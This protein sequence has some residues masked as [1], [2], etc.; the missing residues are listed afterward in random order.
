[1]HVLSFLLRAP[2]P[3]RSVGDKLLLS[4]HFTLRSGVAVQAIDAGDDTIRVYVV[5]NSAG[6]AFDVNT[7]FPG[8]QDWAVDVGQLEPEARTTIREVTAAAVALMPFPLNLNVAQGLNRDFLTDRYPTPHA[9]ST[10]DGVNAAVRVWSQSIPAN[11]GYAV[12]DS[13]P[14]PIYGWMRVEWERHASPSG[15]VPSTAM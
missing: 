14:F 8:R 9:Q 1:V 10:Q 7:L 3:R 2:T 5:M 11:V 12:D 6:Y 4:Y 13:Q 15:L